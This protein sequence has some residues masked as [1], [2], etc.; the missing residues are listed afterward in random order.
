LQEL[1]EVNVWYTGELAAPKAMDDLKEAGIHL[2]I[3]DER[4]NY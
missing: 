3:L 1:E 4:K 2:G